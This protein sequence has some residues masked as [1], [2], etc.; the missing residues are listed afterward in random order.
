M[1]P[2]DDLAAAEVA[3]SAPAHNAVAVAGPISLLAMIVGW[4]LGKKRKRPL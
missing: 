4:L 2:D 3:E 1:D